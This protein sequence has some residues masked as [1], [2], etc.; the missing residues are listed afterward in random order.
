M[1]QT[2]RIILA[3]LSL[4]GAGLVGIALQEN[5]TSVA[6]IPVPGDVPTLGFGTTGGVKLGDKITPPV[7]LA[8]A[9][10][11]VG[12]Y[13]GAL[14]RCVKVPLH[15]REYDAYISLAYNI[16]AT[17]FCDSTLVAK[18]N[19]EDYVAGCLHIEDFVCGPATAATQAKPG[20]KCYSKRKPMRIVRGLANRRATERA[21]CEGK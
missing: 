1:A 16:G 5:Y 10:Q 3:A 20:E 13:E 7:A 21:L 17:A 19:E 15:Q 11:D 14:K 12:K 18:L 2:G 6:V 9:L 8:R 4:S